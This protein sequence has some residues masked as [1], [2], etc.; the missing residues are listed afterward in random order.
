[1]F[2]EGRGPVP[3]TLRRPAETLPSAGIPHIIL[4]ATAVYAHGCERTTRDVDVCMRRENLERFRGELVGCEYES[5]PGRSRRFVD[6]ATGAT[7]DVLIA[8]E[9]AG[10]TRKQREVRF[11]DP[12][13]AEIIDGVPLVSLA[14]LI[15]L[16]LV[17][18][19]FQDW[20]DVVNLIR[21]HNLDESYGDQFNP[22]V[23]QAYLRCYYQK[24]EEDRY[25]PEIHDRHPDEP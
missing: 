12:S 1:M 10:N 11:P 8:G 15:E 14:R 5:V 3:E 13:E 23:R 21:V 25:N 9:L 18:W 24:L 16:T 22:L 2:F 7:V 19:R 20:A 4:G 6:D 17:T